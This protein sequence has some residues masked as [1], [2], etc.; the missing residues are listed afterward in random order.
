VRTG[1]ELSRYFE[2]E[3]PGLAHRLALNYLLRTSPLSPP[4]QAMIWMALDVTIYSA[5]L[6]AWYYKWLA[7][8][9]PL[10]APCGPQGKQRDDVSRRPR[11]IE[12][13]YTVDVLYNRAVNC[14]GSGDGD[15]RRTPDPSPGTPRHPSYPSGHSTYTGGASELLSYFFPDYAGEFD[16]LADNAGL[17]RLWAGI[18]YRSDHVEGNKLGRCVARL[19]I[20]QLEGGCIGRPDPCDLPMMH[21]NDRP[22]GCNHL[23]HCAHEFCACCRERPVHPEHA[24]AAH[25]PRATE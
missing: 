21:C 13:D 9:D 6:A 14:H 18:H 7:G 1:R 20:S 5:L 8:A 16:K 2:Q 4:Y 10:D 23:Q 15:R 19:V 11:P 24:G 3:T 12:V 22:P 17:A 25:D